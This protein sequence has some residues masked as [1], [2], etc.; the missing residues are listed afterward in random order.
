MG[1]CSAKI[2]YNTNFFGANNTKEIT[3]TV[4]TESIQKEQEPK[5]IQI[6]DYT[7]KVLNSMNKV[8]ILKI[9][10]KNPEYIQFVNPF[11]N[12]IEFMCDCIIKNPLVYF[13]LNRSWKCHQEVIEK[14]FKKNVYLFDKLDDSLKNH[15]WVNQRAVYYMYPI[16]EKLP[17]YL[18]LLE[19]IGSCKR[20][21]E[22]HPHMLTRFPEKIHRNIELSKFLVELDTMYV[23][24]VPYFFRREY[25]FMLPLIEKNG[26][27]IK[28]ASYK[29]RNN[30]TLA[31]LAV[32]N[33]HH[34]FCYISSELKSNEFFL[35]EAIELNELVNMFIVYPQNN[36]DYSEMKIPKEPMFPIQTKDFVLTKSV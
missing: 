7:L 19:N 32:K 9:I 33:N 16:P 20:I 25:K 8:R 31:K 24:Y 4:I 5:M 2:L 1:V 14:L 17:R 11:F 29:L 6:E 12:N 34:A 10:Q 35:Q 15:L 26:L 27:C 3:E 18:D 28:Y 30:E 21:I 36:V 22:Y 13:H 23:R